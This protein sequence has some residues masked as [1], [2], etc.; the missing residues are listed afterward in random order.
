MIERF[1]RGLKEEEICLDEDR[2]LEEARQSIGRWI[3]E[4]NHDHPHR[5]VKN[6]MP[7]EARAGFVH[8]QPLTKIGAL[9]V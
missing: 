6:R 4:Y 3:E 5:A 1:H 9:C 8:P 7:R 2:S